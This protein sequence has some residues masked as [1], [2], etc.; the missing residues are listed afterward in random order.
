MVLAGATYNTGSNIKYQRETLAHY[1]EFF[2]GIYY[3]NLLNFRFLNCQLALY[4]FRCE[5]SRTA[6]LDVEL[7][8]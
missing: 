2:D 1:I 4:G 7:A 6:F 5:I 3:V 8:T